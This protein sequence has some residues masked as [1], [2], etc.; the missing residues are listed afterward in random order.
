MEEAT[1]T[2]LSAIGSRKLNSSQGKSWPLTWGSKHWQPVSTS[3]TDSI[4]LVA[5]KAVN[6]ITNNWIQSVQNAT[7]ERKSL[8]GISIPQK[9]TTAFPRKNATTSGSI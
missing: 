8:P 3:R 6:G 9:P 4:T 5:S 2:L 7:N 1:T